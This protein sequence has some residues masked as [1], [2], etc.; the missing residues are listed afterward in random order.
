MTEYILY[1]ALGFFTAGIFGIIALII[2]DYKHRDIT[3]QVMHEG[4][5]RQSR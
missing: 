1:Y 3:H 4:L 5:A 2:Q